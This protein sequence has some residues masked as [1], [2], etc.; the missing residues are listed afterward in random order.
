MEYRWLGNTGLHVSALALRAD[1]ATAS[2]LGR[3]G[4]RECVA[5]AMDA[6]I[7]LFAA[8]GEHAE[9]LLGDVLTDLRF[10][11]AQRCM[12]ACVPGAPVPDAHPLQQGHS[13]K[14]LRTACEASLKRLRVEC[15]DL[16]LCQ[17]P[18]PHTPLHETMAA[19]EQL[20]RAGK[21][22]H[23]GVAHWPA[24]RIAKAIEIADRL[25]MSA[26]VFEQAE[27]V[28]A[29]QSSLGLL[30]ALPHAAQPVDAAAVQALLRT[31]TQAAS[32][33]LDATRLHHF[34]RR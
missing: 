29:A 34:D 6:G 1:Q 20:I 14:H 30:L 28:T 11:P 21:L 26:P 24:A 8:Q 19:L 3:A 12:L 27:A 31:Q 32:L 4:L 9:A 5:R 15:L 18:D 10:A 17:H 7:H 13:R 33:M 22:L 23:W 25:G 2:A 16:L